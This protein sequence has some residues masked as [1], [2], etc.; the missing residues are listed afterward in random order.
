MRYLSI[1]LITFLSPI[2]V[3]ATTTDSVGPTISVVAPL[4]ATYTVPQLFYVTVTDETGVASCTLVVSSVYEKQMTYSATA[5]R[6]EAT[7]TFTTERSA[8]SIRAKCEDAVGN[9]TTGPSRVM[10]V[11]DA[12]TS[13]T[14]G[15]ADTTDATTWERSVI[16][17]KSPILVK[18]TCPGGEDFTHR[19]RTVYFLDTTGK[20]HAF[21][22]EKAYF[23]WY[24]DW[25]GILEVSETTMASFTLGKNVTYHP[26]TKML[27]FPSVKT[28]Y[29]VSRYGVLRP[30]A[31]EPVAI[32][33]YG[34]DWNTQID[35][36]SESFGSNYSVGDTV[37]TS[38][39]FDP[40]AQHTSV[41][42]INDNF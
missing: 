35:D 25:S 24:T 41:V 5:S 32:A 9:M 42:S 37:T 6:W 3:F 18:L 34:S 20:R 7:Y 15:Q 28:V 30:V 2:S 19:C 22:N 33:M 17:A 31:S 36:L 16:V 26:G 4:E 14:S 27:K 21:P 29:V 40:S 12:P 23:S 1:L 39:D 8:N 11:H 13:D 38:G 10:S